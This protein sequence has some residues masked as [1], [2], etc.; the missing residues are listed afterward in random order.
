MRVGDGDVAAY[1]ELVRR[2]GPKLHHYVF[3]LTRDT[4]DAEDIVQETFFRIWQ[5]AADYEPRAK[6]STWIHRIA[7][8]LAVDRLRTRGRWQPL[9]DED[10]PSPISAPQPDLLDEQR[11]AHE[12][13][14]AM[15]ELPE[16][17]RA[18]LVLVH[19]HELSGKEAAAILD[20]SEEALESLLA[21]ARRGLKARLGVRGAESGIERASAKSG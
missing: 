19:L 2:Y 21:R 5:R 12:L 10:E 4:D 9:D 6:A 8:N 20:V 13:E 16:R 11:R 1:R 17:Q 15:N 14:A 3:R 7:H 18:A